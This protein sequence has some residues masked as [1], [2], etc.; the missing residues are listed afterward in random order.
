MNYLKDIFT[1]EKRPVSFR[2]N[3]LKSNSTEIQEALN[4]KHIKYTLLE[5]PS[6]CFILDPKHKESDIWSL[7]IYKS[8]KIYMQS[9]SSQVPVEFFSKHD[10]T[11]LKI[12]DACAAPWWKTSQLAAIYPNAE[13]YAFEPQ[14]SRFEKMQHNFKKLWCDN[15]ES[16]HD[17][18]RN[19]WEYIKEEAYWD[20]SHIKKNYKRQKFIVSD[21]LPYLK[22]WGEFIY[23]TC[24]IAPEE[25]EAVSHFILCNYP[26]LQLENID[27][28]SNWHIKSI[29]A[30]QKFEK[31]IFKTEISQ[32]SLRVI[33]SE[34]S[35]WF[36]ISKFIKKDT[37]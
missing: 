10:Y 23:S 33:P 4:I 1:L 11:G 26:E 27:F 6:N 14:K 29:S 31:Q 12:L 5:F 36:F 2:V 28:T 19:I 22:T 30:L 21:V 16:I 37:V 7:D 25:N 3:T 13:I 17:E 9:I 35:E 18:I 32:K 20:L 8:W 15:I 34:Y 24:T